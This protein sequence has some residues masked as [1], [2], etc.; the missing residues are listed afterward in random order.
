MKKYKIL[1]IDGGG[2]RGILPAMILNEIEQ[3][4]RIRTNNPNA[5]LSDYFDM[6][7]GT[8]A[9]GMLA[10]SMIYNHKGQRMD[11]AKAVELFE[12]GGPRIF[13][14]TAFSGIRRL[15]D[16]IYP[17]KNIE[18]VLEETF[19]ES[20]L[21]ESH[22]EGLITAYD[23]DARA[24]LIFDTT[25]AR[26]TNDR[27]YRLR[28]V[29][30]STSAAPTYFPVSYIK[31]LNG[32]PATL[33]DGGIFAN[34]PSLCA[35]VEAK[36]KVWKEIGHEPKVKDMYVLSIGTGRVSESYPYQKSKNWG[37]VSW[38]L[39]VIDILQS[40]GAEV[41]SYQVSKLFSAEECSNQYV[42]LMPEIGS[43]SAKMDDGTPEN[44]SKLKASAQNWIK[45]NSNKLDEVLDDLLQ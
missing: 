34:D 21:S 9:G 40:A 25:S 8:S 15:F 30:R 28:D 18:A 29:A 27:N 23:I 36:K 19:G 44:I 1:S 4:L 3:R 41:I 2:I 45:A 32:N 35:I 12:S 26:R 16:A 31:S 11:L 14:K 6:I 37:T 5:Y 24:A 7:A 13:K 42:R 39:P 43:A 20:T 33:V 10:C 38:V 22:T 17:A